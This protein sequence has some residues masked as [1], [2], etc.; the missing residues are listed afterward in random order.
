MTVPKVAVLLSCYNGEKYLLKQLQSIAD[1]TYRNIEI[2]AHDDGSTDGTKEI[3]HSFPDSRLRIVGEGMHY[4][5]PQCFYSLLAEH[6]D[7]AYF[8][9]SDQDDLWMPEKI[10]RAVE[11]LQ[12]HGGNDKPLLYFCAH[13]KCDEELRTLAIRRAP[14]YMGLPAYPLLASTAPGFAIVINRALRDLINPLHFEQHH[15]LL[16]CR[17]AYYFGEIIS[18]PT[19]LAKHRGHSSSFTAVNRHT[20]L[21]KSQARDSIWG[22]LRKDNEEFLRLFADQLTSAQ[23]AELRRFSTDSKWRRILYPKRLRRG[24]GSELRLRACFLREK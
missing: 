5:Y 6:T 10:A 7:A 1:Q 14:D 24:I 21:N 20:N 12:A 13:E 11:M 23:Q 18:D 17:A 8:A 15:D 19:P 4:G 22:T 9:F 2:L 3:L 16:L